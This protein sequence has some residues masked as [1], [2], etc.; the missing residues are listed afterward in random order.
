MRYFYV[1]FIVTGF[2]ALRLL[3]LNPAWLF[4]PKGW[5]HWLFGKSNLPT[6]PF[7]KP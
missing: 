4:L 2:V 5:Q 1:A 6:Y 3:F 7:R